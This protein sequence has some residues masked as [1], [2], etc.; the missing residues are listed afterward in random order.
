V[1]ILHDQATAALARK[2]GAVND[3]R[4]YRGKAVGL[5][6][7]MIEGTLHKAAYEMTPGSG[8][9]PWYDSG[10]ELFHADHVAVR[11]VSTTRVP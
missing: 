4:R 6:R 3:A 8:P 5:L 11:V 1:Q 9:R 2:I 7:G 10:K